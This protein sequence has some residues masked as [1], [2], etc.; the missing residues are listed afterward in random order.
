MTYSQVNSS[1]GHEGD[2]NG[3]L[4]AGDHGPDGVFNSLKGNKL[5][6]ME[7]SFSVQD[8]NFNDGRVDS[9]HEVLGS[10]DGWL[11]NGPVETGTFDP[12]QVVRGTD[13]HMPK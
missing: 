9:Q 11:A 5:T 1:S 12:Q 2:L 3:A 6:P 13:K 7:L 8:T 4:F 10:G